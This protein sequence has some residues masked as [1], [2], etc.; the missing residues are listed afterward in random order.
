LSSIGTENHVKAET[1]TEKAF[2]KAIF[3]LTETYQLALAVI[4]TE[5][6]NEIAGVSGSCSSAGSTGTPL[7]VVFWSDATQTPETS[8]FETALIRK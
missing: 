2:Q 1:A 6:W 7:N 5:I 3:S 8:V 4:G